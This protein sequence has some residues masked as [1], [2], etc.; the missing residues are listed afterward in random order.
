MLPQWVCVILILYYIII[1]CI[2]LISWLDIMIYFFAANTNAELMDHQAD[3]TYVST[4]AAESGLDI[5]LRKQ[6]LVII[7]P[8][9]SGKTK[10]ALEILCKLSSDGMRIMKLGKI[11][12]W[13]LAVNANSEC[14][15]WLDNMSGDIF[16]KNRSLFETMMACTKKGKIKLILTMQS[17]MYINHKTEFPS[18]LVDECIVDMDIPNFQLSRNVKLKI[19]TSHLHNNDIVVVYYPYGDKQHEGDNR[20]INISEVDVIVDSKPQMAFPLCCHLFSSV[21]SNFRKGAAFFTCPS[22][23]TIRNIYKLEKYETIM[24]LVLAYATLRNRI[25]DMNS[26]DIYLLQELS[27]LLLGD[28][29]RCTL[30]S[31]KSTINFMELDATYIRP[32]RYNV[33][34]IMHQTI[35]KAVIVS[36]AETS[37]ILKCKL[38]KM[39]NP[40]ILNET[41]VSEKHNEKSLKN[42]SVFNTFE[43]KIVVPQHYNLFVADIL[44]RRI[45]NGETSLFSCELL[46][47]NLFICSAFLASREIRFCE[48]AFRYGCMY[49]KLSLVQCIVEQGV[50]SYQKNRLAYF[51][52]KDACLRGQEKII[53]YFFD[54]LS[55]TSSILSTED[56][57]QLLSCLWMHEH[58]YVYLLTKLF[59]QSGQLEQRHCQ[60]IF[61]HIARDECLH[62]A[63]ITIKLFR[64]TDIDT[65]SAAANIAGRRGSVKFLSFLLTKF[66][67]LTKDVLHNAM[68]GTCKGGSTCVARFI[69]SK[70]MFPW[71]ERVQD[72]LECAETPS[73]MELILESLLSFREKE[74][75][76][77]RHGQIVNA[78]N[79]H[80]MQGR[81]LIVK[82]IVEK[83]ETLSD[84]DL[85]C[86][87]EIAIKHGNVSILDCVAST[88]SLSHETITK[89]LK[90][91][92]KGYFNDVVLSR[93]DD[94]YGFSDG[95]IARHAC[96]NCYSDGAISWS[97]D[98]T[99]GRKYGYSDGS[100]E[101]RRSGFD[102]M[103]QNYP[104]SVFKNSLKNVHL[105]YRRALNIAKVCGQGKELNSDG[106]L[107]CKNLLNT[108]PKLP[109][110][111]LVECA[112]FACRHRNTDILETLCEYNP[113]IPDQLLSRH[114][115]RSIDY[116]II[117][118]IYLV[119]RQLG[120]RSLIL[121]IKY[122]NENDTATFDFKNF[123]T[124]LTCNDCRFHSEE[125]IETLWYMHKYCPQHVE[126]FLAHA[127]ELTQELTLDD[128]LVPK[129][130]EHPWMMRYQFLRNQYT[131]NK[132][133]LSDSVE[134]VLNHAIEC[135]ET[136]KYTFFRTVLERFPAI[137][138]SGLVVKLYLD[139]CGQKRIVH[140]MVVCLNLILERYTHHVRKYVIIEGLNYAID[141]IS[142]GVV[143]P[144]IQFY[145]RNYDAMDILP[146]A[147]KMYLKMCKTYNFGEECVQLI[148]DNFADMITNDV[149]IEGISHVLRKK[150]SNISQIIIES[151]PCTL[152]FSANTV[153]ILLSGASYT[154]KRLLCKHWDIAEH[155]EEIIVN[156]KYDDPATIWSMLVQKFRSRM[157]HAFMF[158]ILKLCCKTER[159]DKLVIEA[160]LNTDAPRQHSEIC[161]LLLICNDVSCVGPLLCKY[162]DITPSNLL[163][164]CHCLLK[165]GREFNIVYKIL[166]AYLKF[167][168]IASFRE[169]T[170]DIISQ[171]CFATPYIF[172]KTDQTFVVTSVIEHFRNQA[173]LQ[174]CESNKSYVWHCIFR[175]VYLL[176]LE[177]E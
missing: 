34:E 3:R 109:D 160:I 137:D 162:N 105:I 113:G 134:M 119:S 103:C 2:L 107:M 15:V 170:E 90:N 136:K 26:I 154:Y 150:V 127:Y 4:T 42:K 5:I 10:C 93:R 55:K 146:C 59:N 16:I 35:Y 44:V 165:R 111:L 43:Y 133:K 121:F 112:K 1:T 126:E 9:G 138:I 142:V 77:V 64:I 108:N 58:L 123:L 20:Q 166:K 172:T 54:G 122:A 167:S 92:K 173:C 155:M 86:A 39:L 174:Y 159:K 23:E 96:K 82:V 85:K 156:A 13:N 120:F 94:S 135:Q 12:H 56:M 83:C 46:D 80:C 50:V 7:G 63:E 24:Y 131:R 30:V 84:N 149:L 89:F 117:Q 71:K 72:Y 98:K 87:M 32:L 95:V 52:L 114:D 144:V 141:N 48:K 25:I 110:F 177:I 100:I 158:E 47:C 74:R 62:I 97:N 27:A 148:V 38:I 102:L 139:I 147:I 60:S 143:Q 49:G 151:C 91:V 61:T 28:K 75:Y 76:P 33:Y 65:I 68:L 115:G 53:R 161:R 130:G 36:L 163:E 171:P 40:D 164:V 78:L 67:N 99:H 101:P 106:I 157:S 116:D 145:L 168:R 73:I 132:C 128:F 79:V 81:S 29:D 57:I 169:F 124:T 118:C 6:V 17:H 140:D 31:L 37:W 152:D 19:L 45:E 176:Y 175:S 69:L 88:F 18:R 21:H 8:E 14:C 125:Y 22:E 11:K 51:G 104:E 41:L 153:Y 129:Y 66:S 70:D